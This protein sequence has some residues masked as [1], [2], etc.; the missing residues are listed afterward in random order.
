MASHL[1]IL[2]KRVKDIPYSEKNEPA[3]FNKLINLAEYLRYEDDYTDFEKRKATAILKAYDMDFLLEI[4]S[5]SQFENEIR[6]LPVYKEKG[7]SR[8]CIRCGRTLT[9]PK[10]IKRGYGPTCYAKRKK[11]KDTMNNNL[12]EFFDKLGD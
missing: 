7:Y 8:T 6:R 1:T 12:T 3:F 4:E 5:D 11:I 2:I 9:N 10:S